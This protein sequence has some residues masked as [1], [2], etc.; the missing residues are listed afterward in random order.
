[1]EK[2]SRLRTLVTHSPYT[3]KQLKGVASKLEK[4]MATLC[5]D[6]IKAALRGDLVDKEGRNIFDIEQLKAALR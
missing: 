5:S 3:Y 4:P 1:M 6:I 2:S